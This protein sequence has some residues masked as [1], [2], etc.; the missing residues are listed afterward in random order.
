MWEYQNTDELYHHGVIGMRWGHRKQ[1]PSSKFF[2]RIRRNRVI[3]GIRNA[4]AKRKLN[5][6]VVNDNKTGVINSVNN[7]IQNKVNYR[8]ATNDQLR[9]A[10]ERLK[11][12]N[13][14]Q[15]QVNRMRELNPKKQ[16]LAKKAVNKVFGEMIAPS[17]MTAGQKYVQNMFEK[18]LQG[19]KIITP[20]EKAASAATYY[21]NL[22]NIE[23]SKLYLQNVA[24]YNAG[25][26]NKKSN[27]KSNNKSKQTTQKAVENVNTESTDVLLKRNKLGSIYI[28]SVLLKKKK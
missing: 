20:E 27:N 5:A 15:V 4:S 23:R 22:E 28:N 19:E 9:R 1:K 13:D 14:Y 17:L 26:S 10:T 3:K 2:N 11:L 18:V 21:K 25:Q 8:H 12:Q 6:T 24:K 7:A 16:S